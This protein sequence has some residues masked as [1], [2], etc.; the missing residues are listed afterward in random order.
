MRLVG[1]RDRLKELLTA[2]SGGV[3]L[4]IGDGAWRR[5]VAVRVGALSR[6]GGEGGALPEFDVARRMVEGRGDV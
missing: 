1:V 6:S 5:M 3:A 4:T 2:A